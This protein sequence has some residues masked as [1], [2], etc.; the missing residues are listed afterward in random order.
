MLED[1][2]RV[3]VQL[4]AAHLLLFGMELSVDI[5]A[6]VDIS[7]RTMTEVFVLRQDLMIKGIDLIKLFV[8]CILV[9]VDLILDFACRRCQGYHAQ[10]VEHVFAALER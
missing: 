10:Y 4:N 8:R 2:R 6:R 3:G 5:Y 9:S 1:C 7:L